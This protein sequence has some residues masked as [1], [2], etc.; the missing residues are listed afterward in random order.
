[1]IKKELLGI[2]WLLFVV[3]LGDLDEEL[4][5]MIVSAIEDF[6]NHAGKYLS[7]VDTTPDNISPS[8][9]RFEIYEKR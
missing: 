7:V 4:Y 5:D 3:L 8:I 1:M 6:M 2:Q 9:R